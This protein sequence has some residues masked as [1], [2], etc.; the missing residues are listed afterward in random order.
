[1]TTPVPGEELLVRHLVAADEAAFCRALR[2]WPA[3]EGVVFA[4]EYRD[5]FPEYVNCLRSFEQGQRLPEGWVPSTTLFGFV[6]D[7]II[8]RVQ[9]RHSLNERLRTIGGQIGYAVLPAFR[10]RGY[11][12]ALLRYALRLASS[13][14]LSRVLVTC[15]VG[16]LASARVAEHC[17]G[18]F[19]GTFEPGDGQPVKRHYWLDTDP[20]DSAG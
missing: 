17:G 7:E 18:V 19:G 9:L 15:D 16:N 11:A 1:M 4:P 10:N 13:L 3:G 20:R 5:N 14:G 6:A 12:T 8:G 2:A